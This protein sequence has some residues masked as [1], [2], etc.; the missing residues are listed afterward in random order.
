MV[1]TAEA[2]VGKERNLAGKNEQTKELCRERG[3]T[4]QITAV[5]LWILRTA[6]S[7]HRR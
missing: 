5:L 6:L 3:R 2:V 4:K 7:I 1:D